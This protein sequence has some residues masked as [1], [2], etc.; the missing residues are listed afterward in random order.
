MLFHMIRNAQD[1]FRMCKCW[2]RK[3]LTLSFGYLVKTWLFGAS[4]FLALLC[5]VHLELMLGWNQLD[6]VRQSPIQKVCALG[7]SMHFAPCAPPYKVQLL[8]Y[9]YLFENKIKLE[10]QNLLIFEKILL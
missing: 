1:Q 3:L 8:T 10:N 7:I 9:A 2:I 5:L 6:Y 4:I